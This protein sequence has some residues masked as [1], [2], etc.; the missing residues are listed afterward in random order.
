VLVQNIVPV[1]ENVA[2][3][4]DPVMITQSSSHG[5]VKVAQLSNGL[6]ENFKLPLDSGTQKQILRIVNQQL[7][8]LLG[9]K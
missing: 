3:A 8:T 2:E 5:R 4:N 6:T 9:H 1:G 7:L